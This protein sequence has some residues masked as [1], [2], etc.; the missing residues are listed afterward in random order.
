M[1]NVRKV[2][3]LF[4]LKGKQS[5]TLQTRLLVVRLKHLSK[6]QIQLITQVGKPLVIHT[7]TLMMK[8]NIDQCGQIYPSTQ[9]GQLH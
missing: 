7:A 2:N 3:Y 6:L 1:I 8:M 5:K 9:S 4:L